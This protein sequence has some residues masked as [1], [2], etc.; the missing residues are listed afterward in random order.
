[1]AFD[2]K[3]NYV[4]AK[5]IGKGD[6]HQLAYENLAN[7]IIV[8]ACEDYVGLG[9]LESGIVGH[10]VVHKKEIRNFFKSQWFYELTDIDPDYLL[11]LLDSHIEQ[12]IKLREKEEEE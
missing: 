10:G 7:A 12:G 3:G 9:H 11:E 6:V 2:E 8:R 1:M 5:D 4:R